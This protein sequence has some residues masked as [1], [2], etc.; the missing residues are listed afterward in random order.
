MQAFR[1][2]QTNGECRRL[3]PKNLKQ[4]RQF[5]KTQAFIDFYNNILVCQIYVL[6][7]KRKLL[8]KEIVV[9]T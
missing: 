4:I 9:P 5:A 8:I 6:H 7:T 2:G 1:F 3:L